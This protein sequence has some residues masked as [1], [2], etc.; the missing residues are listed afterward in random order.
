MHIPKKT[1]EIKNY[2]VQCIQKYF[3]LQFYVVNYIG[4][5]DPSFALV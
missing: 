5:G 3:I 4:K 1:H 2:F